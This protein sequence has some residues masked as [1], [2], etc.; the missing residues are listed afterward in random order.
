[1][2]LGHHGRWGW[3]AQKRVPVTKPGPWVW[4]SPSGRGL[5]VSPRAVESKPEQVCRADW[6]PLWLLSRQG[7]SQREL[8]VLSGSVSCGEGPTKLPALSLSRNRL[9]GP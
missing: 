7:R 5:G 3:N 6:V 9:E 2:W 4:G 8:R 1:M